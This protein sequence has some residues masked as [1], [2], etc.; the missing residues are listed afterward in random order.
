MRVPTGRWPSTFRPGGTRPAGS[1]PASRPDSSN[2][3]IASFC[4]RAAKGL[5]RNAAVPRRRPGRPP[6][7]WPAVSRRL[8]AGRGRA[9]PRPAATAGGIRP[10]ISAPARHGRSAGSRTTA[11]PPAKP[12]S[13]MNGRIASERPASAGAAGKSTLANTKKAG[14]CP[15]NQPGRL[16]KGENATMPNLSR[17]RRPEGNAAP[18]VAPS[19]LPRKSG[20][21]RKRHLAAS[22]LPASAAKTARCNAAGHNVNWFQPWSTRSS[23]YN[24]RTGERTLIAANRR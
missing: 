1:S 9:P 14:R 2:W 11:M 24:A 16:S 19:R 15:E 7:P 23:R 22:S 6:P 20:S 4:A 17:Q 18:W 10:A 12:R 8:A 3:A 13:S 5:R 21:F